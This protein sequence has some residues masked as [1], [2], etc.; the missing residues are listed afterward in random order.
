MPVSGWDRG[1]F[2]DLR[3]AVHRREGPAFVA[4][5]EGR[6]RDEVLQLAGEGDPLFGGGRNDLR[7]GEIRHDSP[8]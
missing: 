2:A 1:T 7:T 4:A 3:G 5:L 6:P 8:Y